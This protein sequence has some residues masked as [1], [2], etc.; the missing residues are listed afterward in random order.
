MELSSPYGRTTLLAEAAVPA[1]IRMHNNQLVLGE[2]IKMRGM[3][4]AQDCLLNGSV[5]EG[6]FSFM[7]GSR[8][9]AFLADG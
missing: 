8:A 6:V 5:A 9:R 1:P 4:W 2:V 7:Y 3:G